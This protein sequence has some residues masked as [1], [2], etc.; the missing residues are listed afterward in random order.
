[1]RGPAPAGD[2][3]TSSL[4]EVMDLLHLVRNSSEWS[5]TSQRTSRP[6]GVPAN[7]F[8]RGA[9]EPRTAGGLWADCGLTRSGNVLLPGQT[10]A[11]AMG[12]VGGAS[13]VV[14]LEP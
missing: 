13:G 7:G 9:S 4:P 10:G 8:R 12:S 6:K 3:T 14:C 2:A 11:L 5:E 1:M